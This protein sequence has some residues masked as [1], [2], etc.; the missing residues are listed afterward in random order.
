MM[1]WASEPGRITVPLPQQYV[2]S[3]SP[4][5]TALIVLPWS[6]GNVQSKAQ[7]PQVSIMTIATAAKTIRSRLISIRLV[8]RA[9]PER[10]FKLRRSSPFTLSLLQSKE[11]VVAAS[12][13]NGTSCHD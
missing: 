3:D 6:L 13:R 11:E 9:V 4:P 8:K 12:I 2:D 7:A 10:L 5:S 1:N